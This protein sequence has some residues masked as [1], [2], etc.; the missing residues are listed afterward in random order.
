MTD[1]SFGAFV[2]K[3]RIK[4]GLSQG[5]MAGL[6]SVD[7]QTISKI[8]RG[9]QNPRL[10]TVAILY[11]KLGIIGERFCNVN[12][13]E[14]LEI[15]E[16]KEQIKRA[17]ACHDYESAL[18]LRDMLINKYSYKCR[19]KVM[20]QFLAWVDAI[21]GK[22]INGEIVFYP[23]EEKIR[24]LKE[25]IRIT[26]PKFNEEMI[27]DLLFSLDETII[28]I[29]IANCYWKIG[30]REKSLWLYDNLLTYIEGNL[31][32]LSE[33]YQIIP[34]ITYNYSRALEESGQYKRCIEIAD[35]GIDNCRRFRRPGLLGELL[36]NKACA[37]EKLKLGDM[38][39]EAAICGFYVLKA[40]GETEKVT[41]ALAYLK[42]IHSWE[43]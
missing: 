10:D 7:R 17:N 30:E 20:R 15:H 37:M 34:L 32:E 2:K 33:S 11:Q 26:M 6:L 23:E 9:E 41:T 13:F 42:D 28:V 8:E 5:K 29:N 36:M 24:L 21:N 3:E 43:S 16:F 19:T 12:N 27:T 38:G 4:R 35:K 25:A 40:L 31:F 14:Q 18:D 1:I 22:R 39:K